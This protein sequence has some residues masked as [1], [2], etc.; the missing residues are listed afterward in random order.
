[1]N[2]LTYS[3]CQKPVIGVVMW[4]TGLC[5]FPPLFSSLPIDLTHQG[6]LA[7]TEFRVKVEKSY[8]LSLAVEFESTQKRLD[9]L[10]IGNHFNQYCTGKINYNNIPPEQKM[11]LG[12]PITF[13][14][15]IRKADNKQIIFNQ[16]FQSLCSTGHDG[17]NKN[18]RTIGWIPLKQ[19]SYI[20]EVI[21][22]QS[23]S[24]LKNTK[25]TLSLNA[26]NGGK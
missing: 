12:Q 26:S 7:S 8:H 19:G 20:I 10:A 23:H 21:N 4:M 15:I 6:T 13:Q 25:T 5:A 3:L 17:K 18:Y 9:D 2:S 11:G 1:M 24:Q 14:V 16:Q 22:L